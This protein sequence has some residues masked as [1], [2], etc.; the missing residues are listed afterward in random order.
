[1][2]V[3]Y[4]Y[5]ENM[6][7]L[8]SRKENH[9]KKTKSKWIHPHK[10]PKLA[11]IPYTII[12]WM[13]IEVQIRTEKQIKSISTLLT[14]ELVKEWTWTNQHR[15]ENHFLTKE[16]AKQPSQQQTNHAPI[17]VAYTLTR[18][19][20]KNNNQI[21]NQTN[22]SISKQ[23]ISQVKNKTFSNVSIQKILS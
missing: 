10:H 19:R 9:P 8:C 21:K 7:W 6:N 11:L 16:T 22:T 12:T 18:S 23:N 20:L 17:L 3:W 5:K 2:L 1:M 4:S 14:N 15:M 13:I